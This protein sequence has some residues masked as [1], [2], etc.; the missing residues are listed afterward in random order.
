MNLCSST[1]EASLIN[2]ISN[3]KFG[4]LWQ[5]GVKKKKKHTD[6]LHQQFNFHSIAPNGHPVISV[7]LFALLVLATT[8]PVPKAVIIVAS[9]AKAPNPKSI[10]WLAPFSALY[11]YKRI[12]SMHLRVTPFTPGYSELFEWSLGQTKPCHQFAGRWIINNWSLRRVTA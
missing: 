1:E 7:A 12:D 11:T 6:T 4:V 10:T 5:G 2:D 3:S 8:A 9:K